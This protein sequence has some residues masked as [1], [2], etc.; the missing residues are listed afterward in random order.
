MRHSFSTGTRRRWLVRS[1]AF[2][3]TLSLLL[4]TG[5]QPA[6]A[7][8][9]KDKQAKREQA[10]SKAEAKIDPSFLSE[11]MANPSATYSIIVRSTPPQAKDKLN[12]D[13]SKDARSTR[14]ADNLTRNGAQPK[15]SLGIV[16]GASARATGKQILQLLADRDT[17]SIHKN[18]AFK[19]NYLP[20]DETSVEV[21]PDAGA[22]DAGFDPLTDAVKVTS[23]G[24]LEVKAPQV[25]SQLG[26][27][28]LGIGVVVMDSGVYPH[29]DLAGR[30]AVAVDV[31][32]P[33]TVVS[34][35][36][37]GDPGGHGTHVAGLIAGDGTSSGGAFTGVAPQARIIDV[38]VIDANGNSNTSIVLRGMNWVLANRLT[39]NIRVA[40]LSFGTPPQGSYKND[41]L[42]T[43]AEVLGFAN[44]ATVVAAGNTGPTAGSIMSPGNDPYVITVGALDDNLTSLITDDLMLTA[45]SVGPTPFNNLVKPDLVAPG[46][47]MVS[48]LSPGSTLPTLYPERI[49]TAPG[50][51]DAQY[52]RLSGTSMAAPVVAGVVAL[53]LDRNA[54]LNAAQIKNRLKSTVTPLPFGTLNIR[55]KGLVNALTAVGG[56]STTKEYSDGRVTD[57]FA[58]DMRRFIQGQAITWKDTTFNGGVDSLN[59][60][61]DNITWENIT[62][63]NITWE[64]ITWENFT[65]ENITWENI[66]WENITW[67]STSTLST[68]ALSGTGIG[69]SPLD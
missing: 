3:I 38:R 50:A 9:G 39:Y 35:T 33:T 42:A 68:G 40:N 45:S 31:T 17:A 25:W 41:V 2:V 16:G 18:V 43:A 55:G 57:A 20:D 15:H 5:A 23:P 67:E 60:T 52:F 65:W 7:D 8:D 27:T 4:A 6:A 22:P 1:L 44:I 12:K 66:T 59:I 53:M 34:T 61:W 69:W 64:N 63:D 26:A 28:G 58:K 36:P 62:W 19:V 46:R 48:L 11:I 21:L 10:E 47:K 51:T 56:I 37:L 30:I 14:A 32:G 24:I 54:T 29:A 49:V 13:D